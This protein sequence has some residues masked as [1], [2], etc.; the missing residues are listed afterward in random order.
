MPRASFSFGPGNGHTM[1]VDYRWWGQEAYF[2]N[3]KLLEKRW[4]MSFV[5]NRVFKVVWS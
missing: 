5:G 2:V 3:G 4:N 1:E